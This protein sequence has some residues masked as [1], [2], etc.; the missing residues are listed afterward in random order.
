MLAKKGANKTQ[1][2]EAV[3]YSTVKQIV[4]AVSEGVAG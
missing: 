4:L 3:S 1:P 2:D